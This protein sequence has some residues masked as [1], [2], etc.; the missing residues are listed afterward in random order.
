L[1]KLAE[2]AEPFFSKLYG[3][4]LSQSSESI[5]QVERFV[6]VTEKIFSKLLEVVT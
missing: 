3:L 2:C 1:N 4:L 6:R 5:L